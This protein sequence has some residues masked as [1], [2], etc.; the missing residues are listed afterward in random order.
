MSG[1]STVYMGGQPIAVVG[2]VIHTRIKEWDPENE[3]W[4]YTEGDP[5]SCG[6]GSDTSFAE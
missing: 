6:G 1:A 3:C 5:T 2:G 4:I